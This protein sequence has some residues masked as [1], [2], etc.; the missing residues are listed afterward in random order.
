[1]DWGVGLRAGG[2]EG[3]LVG[4]LGLCVCWVEEL[5]AGRAVKH[6]CKTTTATVV[7]GQT[8]GPLFPHTQT[9]SATSV[10]QASICENRILA[11]LLV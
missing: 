11:H 6:R 1:M 8:A 2:W 9:H 3:G 4:R 5:D 10:A 7:D